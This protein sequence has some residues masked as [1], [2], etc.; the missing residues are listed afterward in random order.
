MGFITG[1]SALGETLK[2]AR[3]ERQLSIDEVAKRLKLNKAMI[4]ALENN[5]YGK[6]PAP[7]FVRG[8]LRSY[9][10]VLELDA[11]HVVAEYDHFAPPDPEL[12]NV[13][14]SVP[15]HQQESTMMWVTIVICL[16]LVVLVV[17]WV[18]GHYPQVKQFSEKGLDA[19]T[20]SSS[21]QKQNA[22]KE[23]AI[24]QE[25]KK[26]ENNKNIN[27]SLP[28]TSSGHVQLEDPKT[29]TVDDTLLIDQEHISMETE[30]DD[31]ARTL[32]APIQQPAEGDDELLITVTGPSWVTVYDAGGYRLLY[33]M[34]DATGSAIRIEG[35]APFQLILGDAWN[36]NVQINGQDFDHSAYIKS[37]RS[38]SFKL[39]APE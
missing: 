5:E 15:V 37:N 30:I 25:S 39:T 6:L 4:V 9:A 8:Y 17:V 32:V 10:A 12:K 33:R 31:T 7:A 20:D 24:P 18:I 26:T 13:L 29:V 11:E 36:V 35:F 1:S 28:V 34:L 38:A 27:D 16:I 3:E 23:V 19:L 2:K 21:A 14:K 22:R